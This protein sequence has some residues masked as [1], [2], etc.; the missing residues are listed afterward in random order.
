[1]KRS[2]TVGRV[3]EAFIKAKGL[4][5]SLPLDQFDV[6]IGSKQTA[7]LQTRWDEDEARR[8]LLLPIKMNLSYVAAVAVEGQHIRSKV[9]GHRR[10]NIEIFNRTKDGS[11]G[12]IRKR[13]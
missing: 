1:M 10:R 11:I 5:L 7:V 2:S 3:K 6:S 13:H 8:W 9:L 4:G 12:L